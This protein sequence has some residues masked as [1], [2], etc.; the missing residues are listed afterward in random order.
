[1]A[2]RKEQSRDQYFRLAKA[3]GYRARSAYKLIQLAN[4]FRLLK[5]GR[6]VLDLG[7]APGGWSQVV[8]SRVGEEGRVVAV[9][10]Q[11]IEPLPGVITLR[12]DI[13]E[14]ET[15]ARV[16]EALGGPADVVIS[17]VSPQ[18]SGIGPTD[19]ARSIELGV[20]SLSIALEVLQPGGAFVVKLF[21]GDDFDRFMA[22]VRRHFRTVRSHVPRATRQESRESYVVGLSLIANQLVDPETLLAMVPDALATE[23]EER[24]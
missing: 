4:R 3:E 15:I 13:R 20:I 8:A 24:E 11:E 1:M 7:A 9:D 12:G 6:V 5:P 16:H 14:D 18:I 2:W 21:R 22:L 23:A 19:H 10:L 17:D